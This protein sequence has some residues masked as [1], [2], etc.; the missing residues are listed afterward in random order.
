MVVAALSYTTEDWL[1]RFRNRAH[2]GQELAARLTDF[3]AEAP[4]IVALPRGGV[5]V[6]HE[7]ARALDAPLDVLIAR[8]LGAPGHPELAI[9]AIAQGGGFYLNTELVARL[10]VTE[11]Y[12]E[13]IAR[14]EL[15]EMDRRVAAYRGDR[16]PLNVHGATAIIVDDGLATGATMLAAVRSLRKQ[17]PRS[18]VVAV[19]VCSP[20]TAA[21]VRPEVDHV[22]CAISPREFRAVG[23]WYE[24]FDQTS[25]DEVIELLQH[26]E[27]TRERERDEQSPPR[28]SEE[29]RVVTLPIGPARL[30]GN[31]HVPRAAR[32]IVVFAHGSGSSRHSPRNRFV[33]TKLREAGFATL[34]L[35]LMTP[36]EEHEDRITTELRFDIDLLASRLVSATDWLGRDP[37][38]QNLPIGYF[39]A[40]TGAAAA[41]VAAANRP[42]QVAEVVSRGGRPDLAE[43]A[44]GAVR[45]PA[46]FI[47]GGDDE[48]VIR[49]SLAAMSQMAVRTKLEIIPHATHLFEESGALSQVA[50]LAM[51]WFTQHVGPQNARSRDALSRVSA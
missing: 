8:K 30:E 39:G 42:E 51:A 7:V 4:I 15:A 21:S 5:P 3:R 10:G 19:P 44:L 24:R 48:P 18:I 33:A 40:S 36:E 35:D 16:P 32:G 12:L 22:V 17:E 37:V 27:H 20:D 34:L 43:S 1:M 14:D 23:I 13:Q 46:L 50:S 26:T 11:A 2:A 25:D 49:L 47:V 6:A 31:L 29:Q 38:T 45:A 41:L 28:P 9:G